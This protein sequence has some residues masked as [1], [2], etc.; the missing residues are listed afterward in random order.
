MTTQTSASAISTA[1]YQSYN[2]DST[3]FSR[4]ERSN[5]ALQTR[6]ASSEDNYHEGSVPTDSQAFID[7]IYADY[8]SI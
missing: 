1:E 8:W 3:A 6:E 2:S 4:P 7:Q 5:P